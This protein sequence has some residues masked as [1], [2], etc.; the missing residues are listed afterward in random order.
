MR[1]PGLV[2]RRN[3]GSVLVTNVVAFTKRYPARIADELKDVYG[4]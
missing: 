4:T 3:E 1:W 2:I